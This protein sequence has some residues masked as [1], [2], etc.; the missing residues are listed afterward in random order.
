MSA[1]WVSLGLFDTFRV[2]ADGNQNKA[3]SQWKGCQMNKHILSRQW[4]IWHFQSSI[5]YFKRPR[6]LYADHTRIIEQ[7]NIVKETSKLWKKQDTLQHT[8]ICQ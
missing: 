8:A 5:Q 6:V 7:P 1:T 4:Q 3:L 2:Y